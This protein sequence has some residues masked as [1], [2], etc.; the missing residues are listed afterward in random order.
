[1]TKFRVLNVGGNS[2]DIPLP[3]VYQGWEH[4]LLD[5]DEATRPDVLCDAR[6]LDRLPAATFDSIYCS[7]NLEHYYRHDAIRVLAGFRHVLKDDGFLHIRVPDMSEVFR[8]MRER[9]L[10]IDDILYQSQAGPISVHDVIYGFGA[11][12][13]RSGNDF[14][15]HKAGYTE[16]SLRALLEEHGFPVVIAHRAELEIATYAFRKPPTKRSA[17]LLGVAD[18]FAAGEFRGDHGP[19]GPH[20]D[21]N[22]RQPEALSTSP[23][24]RLHIGGT[25]TAAGW[26]I[27]NVIPAPCVDHVGNAN[28]LSRFP[29]GTFA[30]LYASH[31]A[32]HLDYRDELAA[33]LTEWHRV[34]AP[35]G[36]LMISV[37]D[38]DALARLLTLTK[39]LGV[40]ERYAVMRMLFGGHVDAHD[41]HLVGLNLEFLERLLR[42]AGFVRVRRVDDFHRFDDTSSMLF[43]GGPISLNLIAEKP[44]LGVADG[45]L[46]WATGE[47]RSSPT[48]DEGFHVDGVQPASTRPDIVVRTA[49]GIAHSLPARLDCRE[50]RALL[51]QECC[52]EGEV[53]FVANWLRPGM[54]ALDIGAGLG[55]FSLLAARAVGSSGRVTAFEPDKECRRHLEAGGRLN[56]LE[57]LTLPDCSAGDTEYA[58]GKRWLAVSEGLARAVERHGDHVADFVRIGTTGIPGRIVAATRLLFSDQSPLVMYSGVDDRGADNSLRWTFASLGYRNYRLLGDGRFLVPLAD[59]E[60]PG[61][62]NTILFAAKPDRAAKLAA[63]GLL[64]DADVAHSL[65]E[66][67]RSAAL[68]YALSLPYARAFELSVAD[69][70]DCPFSEAFVAYAACRAGTLPPSRHLAALYAAFG[71]LQAYCRESATPAALASLARVAQDLGHRR[72]ALDALQTLVGLDAVQLDQ[73]FHPPCGRYELLS[74]A[75]H[76]SEWLLAAAH[77]ELQFRGWGSPWRGTGDLAAL[78]WLCES[79]FATPE[80]LRRLIL[81]AARRGHGLTELISY[82]HSEPGHLN[83]SFWTSDGLRELLV[84]FGLPEI[85]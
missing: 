81:E 24:R 71:E 74:P 72:I 7:H 67:E 16:K 62:F 20:A 15:A 48:G 82:L 64:S 59:D 49:E 19:D 21:P 85:R 27:L 34:I 51:E 77:E 80:T 17:E 31:V 53:A 46:P 56:G 28:D 26:E 32:E 42:A 6:E 14:F 13:E 25:R 50:T 58:D 83:P 73:A 65:S 12:I 35:G 76:E 61:R 2:K 47:G 79:P 38:L 63:S 39:D 33:T 1:M 29:D 44:V 41:Y 78:R 5:I 52:V 8:A 22:S 43:L 68:E 30:E 37:P 55:C 9:G 84:R 60:T 36:R 10:D 4:V 75:G 11:Q 3:P 69:V 57:N 45:R 66:A 54:C 18:L 40:D 70:L 23:V